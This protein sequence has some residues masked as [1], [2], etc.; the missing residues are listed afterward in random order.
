MAHFAKLGINGKVIAVNVLDNDQMLNADG[1][2]DETVGQQKLQEI[3]GWPAELWVQTSY[4][5]IKGRYLNDDGTEHSDQSKAFRGNFAGIGDTWD[6]TNQIFWKK[7]PH[8][9]WT[10]N[11][12]TA[13]WEAPITYP[14]ITSE[15]TDGVTTHYFIYWDEDAYDADNTTG[16]KMKKEGDKSATPTV[17]SWNGTNWS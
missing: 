3:S 5:T 16:W 9:S 10:K 4:N 7:Q 11:I 13:S 2:E 6:E 8:N 1:V 14:S 17:Y 15:V 12:S